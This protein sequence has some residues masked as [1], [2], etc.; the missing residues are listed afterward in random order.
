MSKS[1]NFFLLT[2]L[3]F[4]TSLRLAELS[5]PEQNGRYP[6]GPA[7]GAAEVSQDWGWATF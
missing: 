2:V 5:P 1:V 3:Q 6:A 4:K 7:A